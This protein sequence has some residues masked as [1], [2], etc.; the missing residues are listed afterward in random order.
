MLCQRVSAFR[1]PPTRPPT[2]RL[3]PADEKSACPESSSPSSRSRRCRSRWRAGSTTRTRLCAASSSASL[4]PGRRATASRGG[5]TASG[6]ERRSES[7]K[8]RRRA[9]P[10]FRVERLEH[11]AEAR[12]RAKKVIGGVSLGG[13]PAADRR[14]RK[15]AITFAELA[16]EYIKRHAKLKKSKKGARED[17]RRIETVLIPRW[18]SSERRARSGSTRSSR[19]STST[20]IRARV[21]L[22]TGSR[23]S[24]R[25]STT[26]AS[27]ATRPAWWR[28]RRSKID[29]PPL[30]AREDAR[31]QRRR[32]ARLAA[33]LQDGKT[34]RAWVP[35]LAL[36]RT[37]TCGS[38]RHAVE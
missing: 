10:P 36:D 8:T 24:F 19:C 2:P 13:D 6:H 1:R 38:V 7:P 21:L 28:T 23:C 33:A 30:R 17:E 35:S 22:R 20:A 3:R 9:V 29:G 32:V 5:R 26:S 25:P 11:S 16:R 12:D 4:R 15:A 34:R 27:T 37:A 18:G 31:A 14:E